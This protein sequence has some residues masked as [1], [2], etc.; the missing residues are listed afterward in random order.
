MTNALLEIA[1]WAS[2]RANNSSRRVDII[3]ATHTHAGL[4]RCLATIS[5][6]FFSQQSLAWQHTWGS[7][8][9][10]WHVADPLEI[11]RNIDDDIER[12]E[13]LAQVLFE[14]LEYT[15]LKVH[16]CG[17]MY[18]ERDPPPPER[19]ARACGEAPRPRSAFSSCRWAR[20]GRKL[21]RPRLLP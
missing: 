13:F 10:V 1:T 14:G 18:V 7:D 9:P 15:F 16:A 17:G 6:N 4:D 19:E 5:R 11:L 3:G 8:F 2:V 20:L 12:T 21:A